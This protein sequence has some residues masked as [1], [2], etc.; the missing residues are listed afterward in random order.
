MDNRTIPLENKDELCD[1]LFYQGNGS[2]QTQAL[3]YV[4]NQTIIA[5][6]G[7]LMW[8]TGKNNLPPLNVIYKLHIGKEIADVNLHPFNNYTSYVNPFKLLGSAVT[9]F[10]NW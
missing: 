5:T 8:C 9:R 2:S 7:E 10:S 4:G 1:T 3:K 6:T